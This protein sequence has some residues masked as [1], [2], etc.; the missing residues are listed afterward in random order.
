M[1]LGGGVDKKSPL[2]EGAFLTVY[3]PV[4]HCVSVPVAA[5]DPGARQEV[6][7]RHSTGKLHSEQSR[8]GSFGILAFRVKGTRPRVILPDYL[9][10]ALVPAPRITPGREAPICWHGTY[11]GG[12]GIGLIQWV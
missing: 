11:L 2:V 5:A 6:T 1:W 12:S 10:D 4:Y 3:L 9:L 7:G 8:V